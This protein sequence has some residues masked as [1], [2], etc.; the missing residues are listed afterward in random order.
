VLRDMMEAIGSERV[1]VC[2]DTANSLGAGEGIREVAQ[3][4]APHTV[5][6]HIKD[7]TIERLPYLMGFSISG[8]PAG[9]GM[10]DLPELLQLL[11]PYGR[12]RSAILETW[13]PPE[14]SLESTV[15]KEA[16]WA[17]SSVHYLQKFSWTS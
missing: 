7:Y 15:K 9:D 8:R 10:L 17:A 4:L 1:G 14:E 11:Q 13:V 5:N 3:V 2:L 16:E 12:C 6:L